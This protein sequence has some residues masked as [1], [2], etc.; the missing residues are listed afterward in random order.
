[1]GQMVETRAKVLLAFLT[2]FVLGFAAGALALNIYFSRIEGRRQSAWTG[3][4][5]RERYVKQMTEAV[6]IRPEQMGSLNTILDETREE[7]VEL[8]KRLNP[9]FDDI[10]QRA[11]NAIRAILD[12]EQQARF[13]RFLKRWDEERWLQE[14]AASGP[15][16]QERK[17]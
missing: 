9:R 12:A 1:M 7:F 14:Q 3:R 10:R 13:D 17:P 6:G 4:F 16:A 2:I 8:R 15:K 11:R 5:D